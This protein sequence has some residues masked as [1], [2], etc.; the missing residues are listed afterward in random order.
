MC[1]QIVFVIIFCVIF[2]CYLEK[3]K[4]TFYVVKKTITCEIF[5][6]NKTFD[7]FNK[8]IDTTIKGISDSKL[9]NAHT[10]W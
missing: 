3:R 9:F 6:I 8:L 4:T 1:V 7:V 2:D 10:L 5:Q